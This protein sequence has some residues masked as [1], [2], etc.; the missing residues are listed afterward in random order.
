[1]ST[2]DN[3][4]FPSDTSSLT[5]PESVSQSPGSLVR[6]SSGCSSSSSK[7]TSFVSCTLCF[8]HCS[9]NMRNMCYFAFACFSIWC[10]N[11]NHKLMTIMSKLPGNQV[12]NSSISIPFLLKIFLRLKLRLQGGDYQAKSC[13]ISLLPCQLIALVLISDST[14]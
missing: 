3:S 11:H 5:W 2:C 13:P 9:V 1:M 8:C 4:S 7:I 6:T 14:R 12:M 10:L